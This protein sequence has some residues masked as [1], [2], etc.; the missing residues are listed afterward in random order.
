M[1]V[2]GE[3]RQLAR[4]EAAGITLAAVRKQENAEHRAETDALAAAQAAEYGLSVA[5]YLAVLGGL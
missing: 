2:D 1:L 5:D 4:A 3:A